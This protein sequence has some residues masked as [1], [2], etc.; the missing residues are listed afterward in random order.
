MSNPF[1]QSS[2]LFFLYIIYSS[3]YSLVHLFFLCDVPVYDITNVSY[4]K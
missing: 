1:V 4:T 3:L 2:L